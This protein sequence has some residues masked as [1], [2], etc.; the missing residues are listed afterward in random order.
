MRRIL[1]L[2]FLIL[3]LLPCVGAAEE[4]TEMP[5]RIEVDCLNHITTVFR[6]S[7]DAIV[8]QM[9]CGTGS[10]RW[11]TIQGDYV[12]PKMFKTE[13]RTPWYLFE[14]GYG[15]YGSRIDGNFLF[16]SYIF[17]S[18]DDNDVD[19]DSYAGMGTRSSHGCV[20]LYVED[21]KWIAENCLAGTHVHI[22]TP[23]ERRDYLK[24]L[25][26]ENTYSIDSGISYEAFVG[27]AQT[28][29][30]L[31]YASTGEDVTALQQR[32]IELGLFG[33][34]A[35]GFYDGDLVRTVRAL[36]QYLGLDATGVADPAL[37]D[38][39][40][41][42]D[43]PFAMISTLRVGMS[44]T[45]VLH[46]EQLLN[47]LGYSRQ[48]ADGVFDEETETAVKAFQSSVNR[49]ADGSATPE[50]QQEML[51]TLSDLRERFGETGYA[52][53][54]EEIITETAFVNAKSTLN[55]RDEPSLDG[56]IL[57]YL[58]P[59]TEVDVL[60]HSGDW[61]RVTYESHTG[62]LR[63]D[64][65]KFSEQHL[66]R[67]VY[68]EADDLHPAIEAPDF[69]GWVIVPTVSVTCG[70]VNIDSRLKLRTEQDLE[71][72]VKIYLAPGTTV[73]ILSVE[74]GWALAEYCG[75]TGYTLA[76]YFD[77]YDQVELRGE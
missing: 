8:R 49:S 56:K 33:G 14:D 62:Y 36:Q 12:M 1:S 48:E 6:T 50:I 22:E 77:I 38:R 44:G 43:A 4:K 63:S 7:D 51:D 26:F 65:L 25:L 66:S 30:E 70:T 24:E 31:G 57:T 35:D 47:A 18:K 32:L 52:L 37:L 68:I 69:S 40:K 13:E 21:A 75:K 27:M 20:R 11:P 72:D 39:L 60:E 10:V 71:A 29:G 5:Y 59:G 17:L 16:H 42:D 2:L 34:E 45:A 64:Y 19:W 67:P 73:R 54:V 15:K 41:G 58:E 46:L 76:K 3:F 53:T 28:D 9:L 55:L 23:T 74:N 61:C